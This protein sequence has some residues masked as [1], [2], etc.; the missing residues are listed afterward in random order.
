MLM[1]TLAEMR[2]QMGNM[3]DNIVRNADSINATTAKLQ[4]KIE[5]NTARLKHVKRSL[6]NLEEN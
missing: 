4:R 6:D 3:N 5:F 2:N 1:N